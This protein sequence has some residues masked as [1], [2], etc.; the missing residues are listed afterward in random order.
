LESVSILVIPA[1][2]GIQKLHP[3]N[4]SFLVLKLTPFK[5]FLI[6]KPPDP[7]GEQL[8]NVEF[9][10]AK[11]GLSKQGKFSEKLTLAKLQ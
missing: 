6:P 5:T 11:L 3:K 4:H 2:A 1:N 8:G 7:R 9:W 10:L